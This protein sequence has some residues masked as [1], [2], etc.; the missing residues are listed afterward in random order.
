MHT[1]A[2]TRAGL[3]I[4]LCNA[5]VYFIACYTMYAILYTICYAIRNTFPPV[6]IPGHN[7]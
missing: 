1:H 2:L 6:F 7:Q 4:H 3:H 5:T